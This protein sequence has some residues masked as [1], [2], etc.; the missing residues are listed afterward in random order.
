MAGIN[1]Q[2]MNSYSTYPQLKQDIEQVK[3]TVEKVESMDKAVADMAM[4]GITPF[5]RISS[6]SDKVQHH[7]YLAALGLSGLA[8]MNLPEDCRDLQKGIQQ[9]N[10]NTLSRK[11]KDSFKYSKSETSR[12]I[13]KNFIH[14]DPLYNRNKYQ[15]GFSFFRGTLLER[16]VNPNK[17][18]N[19]N[20]AFKLLQADKTLLRSKFGQFIQKNLGVEEADWADTKIKDIG[21][22]S[23]NPRYL[24]AAAFKGSRFGKLTCKAMHRIPVLGVAAM[25][26]I[27][28][29]KIFSSAKDGEAVKQTVKSGINVASIL[30][31]IGYA[32]AVGSKYF[33]PLGSLIGMGVGA[34]VGSTASKK[35]QE[36]ID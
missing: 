30:A 6:L 4:G 14:Y 5:R 8:L 24:K 3:G 34:V 29:P 10:H 18:K 1:F 9:I 21:H 31:G 15:H 13:Y 23:Q 36:I 35:M 26:L 32:G 22:T 17:T 20:F 27:E 28:L 25:A 16:F 19:K 7:E 33:G 11:T 2:S 12:N